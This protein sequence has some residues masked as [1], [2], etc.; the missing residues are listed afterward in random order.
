MKIEINIEKK[1]FYFLLVFITALFVAGVSAFTSPSTNVGH[2]PSEVGPGVFGGDSGSLHGF[3][4]GVNVSMNLFF[5]N[6]APNNG[7][8]WMTNLRDPAKPHIDYSSTGLWVS[9]GTTGK[10][11][12]VEGGNL[13]AGNITASDT[14]VGDKVVAA[15]VS[16]I[17]LDAVS[18]DISI[19]KS[20]DIT[21]RIINATVKITLGGDTRNSWPME[22]DVVT[23]AAGKAVYETY[24]SGGKIRLHCAG[25]L[26]TPKTCS[27]NEVVYGISSTGTVLCRAPTC[28]INYAVCVETDWSG[29]G[30]TNPQNCPSGYVAKGIYVSDG[31]PSGCP[32]DADRA[33]LECCQLT[34]T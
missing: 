17:T 4:G 9:T 11:I 25:A 26:V 21:A 30:Y 31:N 7:I 5:P 29:C 14:I 2:E 16:S 20:T 3:P 23:C 34:C 22:T 19:L 18:G 28:R 10:N 1:H 15:D 27:G 6:L 32:S 13:T 12:N 24:V 33:K 8:F